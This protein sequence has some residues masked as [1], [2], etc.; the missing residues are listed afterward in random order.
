ME[1]MCYRR[2]P[3]QTGQMGE[4]IPPQ[5][6]DGAGAAQCR[7]FSPSSLLEGTD[8][9][10]QIQDALTHLSDALT[11]RVAAAAGLVSSIH[12]PHSRPRSGTLWRPDVVVASEQVFPK[13][14]TAEI[15]LADGPLA[16]ARV[17]GRRR[18]TNI[19]PP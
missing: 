4:G 10:D 2:K 6:P 15:V 17:P 1:K 13:T 14:D 3:R 11:A 9:P 8:M 18:G 7:S 16:A 12:A 19:L 5:P